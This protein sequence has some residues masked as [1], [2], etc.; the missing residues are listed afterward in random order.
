[1]F[2]LS[3]IK[4]CLWNCPSI[5][6]NSEQK[7]KNS[8]LN[9]KS[10][11]TKIKSHVAKD[12]LGW[13]EIWELVVMWTQRGLGWGVI[14]SWDKKLPLSQVGT[15]GAWESGRLEVVSLNKYPGMKCTQVLEVKVQIFEQE[16][17]SQNFDHR[18]YC[19]FLT[20]KEQYSGF[21]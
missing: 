15:S 9:E 7:L 21:Q 18:I 6:Y 19:G 5:V 1:M 13:W 16:V 11:I 2:M 20:R 17:S 3:V 8:L 4:Q 10:W 12:Q 14:W